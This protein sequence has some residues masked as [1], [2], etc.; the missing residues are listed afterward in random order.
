MKWPELPFETLYAIPSRNGVYRPKE[1]HGRGC[2][3]VNMGELFGFE[4]ISSQEMDLVELCEKD[5]EL[6]SL[7]DGDLLFGRRS[8]VE[9]G[10]GKCSLVVLPQGR[11]TFESSIIRVRINKNEANPRFLYYY[12]R[13]PQGRGRVRSIVSGTNV[14]GIR[15]SELRR[16]PVPLPPKREQDRVVEI[17]STYDNYIENNG[18]RMA[19]LEDAARQI[20]REWFVR[21]RFSGREHTQVVAGVPDGWEKRPLIRCA[22]FLSGGT[23]SKARADFWEGDVPWVSSGELTA[24]RLHRTSL[25]VTPEAVDAGSRM[26][27]AETIL[28]VVRGMSL[29][30]EFRI[31]LTARPMAFNQDL[32]AI[33]A[34]PDVDALLLFHS[35]DAQ[36]DQ[37]RDRAGEASHGTKKLDTAVLSEVPILVPPRPLQRVFREHVALLHA[38]WDNL[39]EQNARLRTARDLLLPKLMSGEIAV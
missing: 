17:L 30:K 12:F 37:I 9:A 21:L 35:L 23:P 11:L 29:A 7:E 28:G 6:N 16:L 32:K 4:F 19:L 38:Q 5:L 15:G 10:A 26:V 8:L 3:I 20:Y 34:A 25:N 1:F 13:S 39:D 2:R 24:M 22:R 18:R 33:V 27:P 36:R 31:G 14:K